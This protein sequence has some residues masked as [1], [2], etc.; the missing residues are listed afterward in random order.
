M[1]K[2]DAFPFAYSDHPP[3][4]H[5]NALRLESF[6][7][8]VSI[9]GIRLPPITNLSIK[10]FK[11]NKTMSMQVAYILQISSKV[12]FNIVANRQTNGRC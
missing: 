4:M 9:F 11:V 3:A 2:K 1:N 12:I 5:T 7:V 10:R 6:A 8:V